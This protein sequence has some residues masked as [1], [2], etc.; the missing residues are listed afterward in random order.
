MESWYFFVVNSMS[1]SSSVC[2]CVC[3]SVCVSVCVCL[4][5][6][7]WHLIPD[8]QPLAYTSQMGKC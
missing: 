3:V 8:N 6:S 4:C 1:S 7:V 2:V 5:L